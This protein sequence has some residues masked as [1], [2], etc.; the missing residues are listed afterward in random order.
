MKKIYL[1]IACFLIISSAIGQEE[2]FKICGTESA[3]EYYNVSNSPNS[4]LTTPSCYSINVFFRIVAKDDGSGVEYVNPALLTQILNAANQYFTPHQISF[5]YAGYNVY[6]NSG[7]YNGTTSVTTIPT[8]LSQPN[9][10]N[11]YLSKKVLYGGSTVAGVAFVSSRNTFVTGKFDGNYASIESNVQSTTL[12]HELGHNLNLEHTFRCFGFSTIQAGG[13]CTVGACA[14]LPISQQTPEYDCR[15]RG[16]FVCDTPADPYG[17]NAVNLSL[18]NPDRTNLMSYYQDPPRDH[19]TPGQGQR[20]RDAILNAPFLQPARSNQ[21]AVIVG[22][23]NLCNNGQFSF[24]ITAYGNPIVYNW[25][26]GPNLQIV[27][28]TNSATVIVKVTNPDINVSTTLTVTVN[29]IVKTITFNTASLSNY[30]SGAYITAGTG[31]IC[32]G[33][34]SK[35]FT[36]NNL[37][38][39]ETFQGWSLSDTNIASL[40]LN[41]NPYVM[42]VTATGNGPQT[43]TAKITNTCGQISLKNKT[44]QIGTPTFNKFTFGCANRSLC[45]ASDGNYSFT[46]PTALNTKNRVIASF[47]GLTTAEASVSTNWQWQEAPGNN[48]LYINNS[49]PKNYLDLCPIAA[50]TTTL[51]VRAKNNSCPD[52]SEWV[53]LEIT[54]VQ[55]PSSMSFRLS[56]SPGVVSLRE[57][58]ANTLGNITTTQYNWASNNIWIRNT[59]D[60]IMEHQ[61]PVYNE[62]VPNYIYVRIAN[63]GCGTTLSSSLKT[64]WAKASTSLNWPNTWNGTTYNGGDAKLGD[65]IGTM[66]IPELQPEQETIV[67]MPF[68]IPNPDKYNDIINEPWR[69]ALLAR[70]TSDSGE[71]TANETDDLMQNINNNENIALKNVTI[72]D[73]ANDNPNEQTV[74]GVIAVGNTFNTPKS[75]YL[76]LVKEDLETGKPIYDEA[77]VSLKLDETLYQAWVRGGKTAERLDNT[78][79]EKVKL[80]K[81]NNVF[82]KDLEL[83]ANETGTLYVKFNFLTKEI[84]DKSKYV[85]HVIQRETGTNKIIGGET[86]VIKKQQRPLFTAEAGGTKYVDKNEPITISAAQINES[87]VYNWYDSDGNLVATGKDLSI[88]TDVGQKFKLEVIRTDGFKDYTEVEVKLKPNTLGIISPNPAVN[89]VNIAY[90]LN[91]VNSAYLMILGS[92]GTTGSSNNYILDLNS[93]ETNIDLSNYSNGFYT[94]ALVCDGQI[95]DAKTLFKE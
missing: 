39:N 13:S 40:A 88:S 79:D 71:V 21:C 94:I 80:V 72:V 55:L 50:G 17:C 22:P 74:G 8:T 1:F 38:P 41:T 59:Q 23:T 4:T 54:I 3:T 33:G 18:Y 53:D 82:L 15:T 49:S 64:Y 86:Y 37:Q 81:G 95:V 83:N 77:E 27:G 67:S 93:A 5:V 28:S 91:E 70:V 78:L 32:G 65:A 44:L 48:L 25:T 7:I 52:F 31:S 14:E 47:Y 73:C 11:V 34:D 46:S 89:T 66:A 42:T 35:T 61:N 36:I 26:A 9:A 76:E 56:Q 6:R 29:G 85:Y 84:T 57:D 19:F 30:N 10:I 58:A 68:M 2:T 51:Q 75:F 90:K 45:I 62:N 12:A 63:K 24:S 92:Y 60:G 87:A 16:D 20:M 43:V 69:F